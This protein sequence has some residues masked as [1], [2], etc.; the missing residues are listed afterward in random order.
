MALPVSAQ[1]RED[2]L[3][4][5]AFLERV[6]QYHPQAQRAN[7]LL[8]QADAEMRK[9]RGAFDPKLEGGLSQKVFEDKNY[10]RY[11]DGGIKWPTRLGGLEFK[12]GYEASSGINL[13][14]EFSVPG[15]G[16]AQVGASLPIGQG[17]LIDPARAGFQQATIGLEAA[18]IDRLNMLNNLLYEA[19]YAYWDWAETAGRVSILV[20]ATQ[21]AEDRLRWISNTAIAGD[22]PLIDTLKASIQVQNRRLERD[23]ALLELTQYRQLLQV[24]LWDE[25][26]IPWQQGSDFA[27]QAPV[28]I[29][30]EPPMAADSLAAMLMS[31]ETQHPE[32]LGLRYDLAWLDVERR[33]KAEKLKPKLNL[34]YAAL[35]EPIFGT[36]GSVV[37]PSLFMDNYKWGFQVSF[38]LFLREARGDLGLTKVKIQDV[39][40]K[41]EEK[42]QAILAKVGVYASQMEVLF[43]QMQLSQQNVSNYRQLL[44]AENNKFRAGESSVFEI[45]VWETQ[46]IESELKLLSLQAKYAKTQAALAWAAGQLANPMN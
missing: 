9:A 44:E 41:Q 3:T 7:L 40:W 1:E 4:F 22:L 16:L 10:Y 32:L 13:N 29:A 24:Y 18:P 28:S 6:A 26:A 12:A 2:L 34:E 8:Q 42:R 39:Q 45:N 23:Q 37:D 21:V 43:D 5:D 36:G 35:N 25:G 11:V 33:M 15:N 38:P 14:P 19:S 27:A 31:I 30:A 20:R 17:L 46:L